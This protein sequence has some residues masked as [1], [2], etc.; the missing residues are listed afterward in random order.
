MHTWHLQPLGRRCGQSRPRWRV[1][2]LL[3]ATV[4]LGIAISIAHGGMPSGAIL[5]LEAAVAWAV[6][7]AA[8]WIGS[9]LVVR[10]CGYRLVTP[11]EEL[12][13]TAAVANGTTE[14][15]QAAT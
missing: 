8:I 15:R 1:A 10:S 6:V 11:R 9:F 3:I 7:P 5:W 14:W 13:L 4:P 2:L 12:A